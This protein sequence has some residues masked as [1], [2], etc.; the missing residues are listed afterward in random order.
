MEFMTAAPAPHDCSSSTMP[1]LQS[2]PHAGGSY[3]KQNVQGTNVGVQPHVS[4]LAR[5]WLMKEPFF[6]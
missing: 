5:S 2:G 1:L 6:I 4:K 3:R